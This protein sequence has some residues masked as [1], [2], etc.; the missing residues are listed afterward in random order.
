MQELID[1]FIYIAKKFE[2]YA[3]FIGSIKALFV[4]VVVIFVLKR[5]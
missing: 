1:L 2:L 4:A 5:A 3:P